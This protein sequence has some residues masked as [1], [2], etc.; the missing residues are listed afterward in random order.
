MAEY[1]NFTQRVR[2]YEVSIWTLQDRFVSVLKWATMDNKGEVQNPEMTLRDD[3]TQELSFTIPQYYQ[4]GLVRI[5]NPLWKHL[6]QQPLEANMH[7]LKVVFNKNTADEAVF[8]FLVVSVTEDHTRDEVDITVKAEGLAFHELGKTGYRISLSQENFEVVEND[9]FDNGYNIETGEWAER[10]VMNLQFWNDLIFKDSDGDW[11]T[12]WTYEVRMDWSAF[13]NNRNMK[14]AEDSNADNYARYSDVLYED[15][16]VSSWQLNGDD[17]K[18][19]AVENLR[20]KERPIEISESNYYNVTQTIAEQFGVFCRYEYEHNDRYEI[21]GRKVIYYNNYIKDTEGH[22]DLTY[23]YSSQA[24]TRTTDNTELTTKLFVHSV[25]DEDYGTL[26]IMNV[27]ANKSREDYILNFDYLTKIGAINEEQIEDLKVFE[28]SVRRINDIIIENQER[29]RI[30][31]NQLIEASANTTYYDNAKKLDLEQ[32]QQATNLQNAL[33]GDGKSIHLETIMTI[34]DGREK[35][36]G[37]YINI[38]VEGLESNG[39]ALYESRSSSTGL[40]GVGYEYP[41]AIGQIIYDDYGNIIRL[42]NLIRNEEHIDDSQVYIIGQYNPHSKYDK[43]IA[44]WKQR[45]NIDSKKYEESFEKEATLNWYLHGSRV[46]YAIVDGAYPDGEYYGVGIVWDEYENSPYPK[47]GD[48]NYNQYIDYE[49]DMRILRDEQ[50]L[51]DLQEQ[52]GD[53][54]ITKLSFDYFY[55]I[56]N[57][58]TT[59]DLLYYYSFYVKQKEKLVNAFERMMGPALREGYWQPED[60]NDY[61]DVYYDNFIL[62]ETPKTPYLHFMWDNSK[63]Y[64]NEEPVIFQANTAGDM[65]QHLTINLSNHLSQIKDHLEDLFIGYL[66]PTSYSAVRELEDT[67]ADLQDSQLNVI[68]VDE[69]G[70]KTYTILDATYITTS[71]IKEYYDEAKHQLDTGLFISLEAEHTIVESLKDQNIE[72]ETTS[73]DIEEET[74][75]GS[76][77]EETTSGDSTEGEI[78]NEDDKTIYPSPEE[79]PVIDVLASQVSVISNIIQLTE[80]VD[81]NDSATIQTV[82]NEAL[83][84]SSSLENLISYCQIWVDFEQEILDDISTPSEYG[85]HSSNDPEN[86]GHLQL[87]KAELKKAE[88]LYSLVNKALSWYQYAL[89]TRQQI[90]TIINN[91]EGSYHTLGIGADCELGWI[92]DTESNTDKIIPVLIVTGTDVLSD[93]IL[94]YIQTGKYTYFTGAVTEGNEKISKTIECEEKDFTFIGYYSSKING[95]TSD[96]TTEKLFTLEPQIKIDDEIID[97]GDFIGD[98][99][100]ASI[101][102][103][104]ALITR[105][106]EVNEYRYQRVFPRLYFSTLKL[107]D[108]SSKLRLKIN[109]YELVSNQD[110]YMIQDDRSKGMKASGIGYY[111]TLRASLLYSYL[112]QNIPMTLD[113]LYTLLN[114]DTSIYLDAIKV[115]KENAFPKVSYEVELCILN[116]DFIRTSYNRLNQIV[117][118][119]DIDLRLEE[120]SGYISAVVL[121]LDKTWE[122]TVEVKNYQTKFEDLFSTIVA[123][124]EAMKKSEGGLQN[125]VKAF[126][127]TGFID[128]DILQDSM[129]RADLDLAFNKGTLTI[130]QKDGIWGVTEGVGVVAFRGGGIF[131]ATTK[132]ANNNWNWNTGIL[133]TGIN[134]DLITAGQLDTSRIKIYSGD[135]VRFQWNGD[136]LF[137][138]KE[139]DEEAENKPANLIDSLQYV[140]YNSEGLFL[141]AEQGTPY[142]DPDTEE[143]KRTTHDIIN[144][145]EVSWKGFTLRN[146][147]NEEVFYADPNT[148]NLTLKGTIEADS[149]KIGGWNIKNDSLSNDYISLVGGEIGSLEL[150]SKNGE[151][152]QIEYNTQ[153]YY[154]YQILG[155]EQDK[156]YYIQQQSGSPKETLVYNKNLV[157]KNLKLADVSQEPK[158]T[159]NVEQEQTLVVDEESIVDKIIVT[160]IAKLKEDNITLEPLTYQ[161]EQENAVPII[162]DSTIQELPIE[163]KEKQNWYNILIDKFPDSYTDYLKTNQAYIEE[164][165]EEVFTENVTRFQLY[166][167]KATFSVNAENGYMTI[168]QGKIGNFILTPTGDLMGDLDNEDPTKQGILDR[169]ELGL[170][171]YVV[172]K[173]QEKISLGECF[174]SCNYDINEKKITLTKLNGDTIDIYL[175]G[176]KNS[177]AGDSSSTSTTCE[178]CA[179]GCSSSCKGGCKGSCSG[180]CSGG[181]DSSC[182]GGCKYECGQKCASSCAG[183]CIGTCKGTCG[184]SCAY[185]TH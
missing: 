178:S 112:C 150:I 105:P 82:I 175:D 123:Q 36:Y 70:E 88:N 44:T 80:T 138:Y 56:D 2:S 154:Q 89:S 40:Y 34:M 65:R 38:N 179:T 170:Q 136:G 109:Q 148:G 81:Y 67:L 182:T 101:T 47:E 8:E 142:K 10:P 118:I 32:L 39:I 63:Y 165:I 54:D 94:N 16:Y 62:G 93:S 104:E 76:S 87:L 141:V 119:N 100:Q 106:K 48:R 125:A 42:Q 97:S 50:D 79:A 13:N 134:A 96:I 146:W 161:D 24:I 64:D 71:K 114:A 102:I 22:I 49:L 116:P 77:E 113:V 6:D 21:I 83:K 66:D 156:F 31:N 1:N 25:D 3:G 117:Y 163:N 41:I 145:V 153:V 52:I 177:T 35:G 84:L 17:I 27:E 29:T 92:I 107:R 127:T 126:T 7:K 59:P 46:G 167:K 20:E 73:G 130:S 60:Y 11:R 129:L 135:D 74:T 53:T 128:S 124:T 151:P 166:R 57:E 169:A 121:K 61:G 68:P 30:I 159:I 139:Y 160:Y 147:N 18:P 158:Y 55:D 164:D 173:L 98:A 162:Y 103:T 28:A 9:W 33:A 12:N 69:T 110:Y 115:S 184:Y 171:N 144:R 23:P 181:C 180:S 176:A 132:D 133:P 168:T 5:L 4:D 172:G 19:R 95:L 174:Y 90:N 152:I 37:W 131:T 137:A 86:P 26:S 51:K 122:D 183:S 140:V 45:Y 15:S 111:M 157:I 149:G 99:S 75:S 58:S 14:K 120:V 43:I 185:N 72:E 108:A 143:I 155:S 78:I 85:D 91:R